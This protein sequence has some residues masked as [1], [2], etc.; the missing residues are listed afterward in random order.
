MSIHDITVDISRLLIYQRVANV[1][2]SEAVK[3]SFMCDFGPCDIRQER[4]MDL[5]HDHC[6]VKPTRSSFIVFEVEVLP[7]I[8]HYRRKLQS[9]ISLNWFGNGVTLEAITP[10]Y[11]VLDCCHRIVRGLLSF[12]SI[13]VR[14]LILEW[15]NGDLHL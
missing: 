4:C 10:G 6:V 9:A 11:C 13:E 15:T 7:H 2:I 12:S 5:L 1:G 3:F 14:S 8:S